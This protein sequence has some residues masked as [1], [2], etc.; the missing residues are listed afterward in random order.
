M[1]IKGE[2]KRDSSLQAGRSKEVLELSEV[3]KSFDGIQ[4]LKNVSIK[5]TKNQITGIIGPNGAGKTTLFN[6]ITGFI[7]PDK[8]IIYY[9]EQS[10]TGL[11]PAQIARIGIARSFQDV[12]ILEEMSVLENVLLFSPPQSGENML[13]ALLPSFIMNRENIKKC[14]KALDYLEIVQLADKVDIRAGDLSYAEQK[15]LNI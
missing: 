9:N 10:I 3:Y 2:R 12:R 5:L 6:V 14:K 7:R 11:S 15:L 1:N 13:F 8:G 4:A